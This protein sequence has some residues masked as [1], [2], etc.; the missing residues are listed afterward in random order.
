[1]LPP[2]GLGSTTTTILPCNLTPGS[3]ALLAWDGANPLNC[4]SGITT[5][6]NG[7][8]WL[9]SQNRAGITRTEGTPEAGPALSIGGYTGQNSDPIYFQRWNEANDQSVLGLVIGDNPE[10]LFPRDPAGDA[11]IIGAQ[12]ASDNY[13][14]VSRY[15]FTGYGY[16]GIGTTKPAGT[17]D[18][19]NTTNNASLCLNGNC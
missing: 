16:L 3:P 15:T 13:N 2:S 1:M 5:D 8:L 4:I 17:L 7:S 6:A 10:A 14:F 12:D 18:V 19:E 9:G 11:F